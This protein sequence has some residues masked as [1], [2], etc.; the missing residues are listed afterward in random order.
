MERYKA[1]LVVLGNNQKEGVDYSKTFTPVVK[2]KIIR[3]FLEVTATKNWALH[4]MDVNNAFLHGDL[5]E[6]V[7][8]HL[9][10]GFHNGEDKN[11]VCFLKK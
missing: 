10:P 8:M 6:E 7:Y 4:Q 3:T 2:M 5:K 11:S 9:P 1:R